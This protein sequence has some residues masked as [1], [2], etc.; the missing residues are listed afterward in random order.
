VN[1]EMDIIDQFAETVDGFQRFA[2]TVER[3]S[4]EERLE[5]ARA[6]LSTLYQVGTALEATQAT[7]RRSSP[8]S[9]PWP[10]FGRFEEF[11]ALTDPHG[12]EPPELCQLSQELGQ[13]TGELLLGL[14]LYLE[15][16]QSDALNWWCQGF[17]EGYGPRI[18]WALP[19]LH[20]A[21]QNFR[22]LPDSA[23]SQKTATIVMLDESAPEPPPG[24][25]G[26]RLMPVEGGAEIVAVHPRGPAEGKLFPGDLLLAIDAGPVQGDSPESLGKELGGGSG[27]TRSLSIYRSGETREIQITLVNPEELSRAIRLTVLNAAAA[28][29]AATALQILGCQLQFVPPNELHVQPAPEVSPA[30]VDALIAAGETNHIWRRAV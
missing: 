1:H 11:W 14:N 7:Q 26:L 19:A 5:G 23:P 30:D 20:A 21:L 16:A 12:H 29:R 18:L 13:I 25:M 9:R 27:T 10:D 6:W 2:S 3:L 24:V 17:E 22:S 8:H 4:L 15:G 28:E